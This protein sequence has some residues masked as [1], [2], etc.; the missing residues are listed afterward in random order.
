MLMESVEAVKSESGVRS[1]ECG[2]KPALPQK[3]GSPVGHVVV[4]A[5][6]VVDIHR[7]NA[8]GVE[9]HETWRPRRGAWAWTSSMSQLNTKAK[10]SEIFLLEKLASPTLKN[11]KL[12]MRLEHVICGHVLQFG[13]EG[14]A[15]ATSP[16]SPDNEVGILPS[17]LC[18]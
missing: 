4:G 12:V 1:R 15:Y 7:V 9:N 16:G 11:G 6:T 17:N 5:I 10:V 13:A 14:R 18:L 2:R 3:L 8:G